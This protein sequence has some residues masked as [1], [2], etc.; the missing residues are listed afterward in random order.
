[1]AL[2]GE[3]PS[4]DLLILGL[5]FRGHLG[6]IHAVLWD[7]LLPPG[8]VE[9]LEAR[10]SRGEGE[11]CG[12]FVGN[13]L[14]LNC[15]GGSISVDLSLAASSVSDVDV[16]SVVLADDIVVARMGVLS[17]QSAAQ[18]VRPSDVVPVGVTSMVV[19]GNPRV[20]GLG[21]PV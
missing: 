4:V 19:R 21:W 15:G 8:P 6:S 2:Q 9:I 7:A 11:S 12:S 18:R 10:A 14:G 5:T 1:M 20:L 13:S 16:R 17:V 3:I